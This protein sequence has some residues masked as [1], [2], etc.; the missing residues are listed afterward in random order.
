MN[1][2][3]LDD[4]EAEERYRKLAEEAEREARELEA[5]TIK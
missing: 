3:F 4:P 1:F 5:K 2:G